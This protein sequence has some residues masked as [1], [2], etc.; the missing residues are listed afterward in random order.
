MLLT[1]AILVSPIYVPL[2]SNVERCMVA[3]SFGQTETLKLELRFPAVPK[4]ED[5]NEYY[6]VTL[7]NT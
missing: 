5:Y 2:S 3:F 7:K 1:V 4:Q 6:L